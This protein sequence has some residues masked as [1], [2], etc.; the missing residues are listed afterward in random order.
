MPVYTIQTPDGRKLKIEAANE[1]AAINGARQW[2]AQ[3]SGQAA[4][5]PRGYDA[6]RR[7]LDRQEAQTKASRRQFAGPLAGLMEASDDFQRQIGRN[8]G[9]YDE[10]AGGMNAGVQ[11]IENLA[12]R[13]TGRPIDV[14]MLA[15]YQ[16]A[17]DREKEQEREFAQERP[18]ANMAATA[19]GIGLAGVPRGPQAVASP[20]RA[21]ASAATLNAPFAVGRQEGDLGERLPGAAVETLVTGALG[22][23]IAAA[24]RGLNRRAAQIAAAPQSPAR[25]LAQEGVELTP[26]QMTGGALQRVEDGLTSVPVLGDA[27]RGA[28]V[29]GLE[30]FD[31]AAINRT[32][33]PIGQALPDNVNVGREGVGFA[34]RAISD[35]Y[36][37]ALGGVQVS[38]DPAFD[39][40]LQAIRTRPGLQG[41]AG[42]EVAGVLDDAIARLSQGPVDGATFKMID[43]DI[44]AAARAARNAAVNTPS[45]SRAAMALEDAGQALDDLLGRV[46]PQALPGKL[47]ADEA[48]A[49]L[50]RVQKAASAAG[51]R[52]GVFSAPQLSSA[53]RATDTGRKAR[54]ARGDALMQDLS[55]AGTAV[56]PSTVP[57]SGTPLR[58][59]LSLGGLTGGGVALGVDPVVAGL[60]ITGVGAGSALYSPQVISLL[61]RLYRTSDPV[62]R[63]QLLARLAI[64]TADKPGLGVLVNEALSSGERPVP[65]LPQQ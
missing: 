44:G 5:K 27:I 52:E 31:R 19:L 65:I 38:I 57:D 47:A 41:A 9:V 3:N 6:A 36:D 25:R 15:A 30:S 13:V 39:A 1:Q 17:A 10:V 32:L 62:L 26:G 59:L 16:A 14:T 48:T 58:S 11:G 54:F 51:A 34:Q 43:A 56:L 55:D 22:T 28:K 23:G 35:A 40:A 4:G 24:G 21:G 7:R 42:D 8:L 29:R 20:L 45:M 61:N 18:R 53:V 2:S 49:N 50:I 63:R 33:A 60:G 64:L 46:A 12:R 37:A